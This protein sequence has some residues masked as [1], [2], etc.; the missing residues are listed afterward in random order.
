MP[1]E[2][3][4]PARGHAEGRRRQVGHETLPAGHGLSQADLDARQDWLGHL[5][6]AKET[7]M[8]LTGIHHLTAVTADAPG[9]HAFYTGRSACGWSRRP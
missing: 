8:Q 4:A 2:N 1:A 9:N 6:S 5:N 3:A 7:R